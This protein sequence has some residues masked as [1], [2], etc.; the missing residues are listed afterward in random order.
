MRVLIVDDE[1]L[2]RVGVRHACARHADIEVVGEAGDGVAA[3]EQIAALAP[4]ALFLDVQMPGL[5]G[6]E[7]LAALPPAQRPAVVFVTAYDEHAVRAFELNALD[8]LLKPF[9]DA[10]FDAAVQR[11]RERLDG[12]RESAVADRLDAVVRELRGGAWADRVLATIGSR[13]FVI[14]TADISWLEAAD[15]YVRVHAGER[16]GL[17]R[18]TLASL[19]QRLDPARFLRVHRSAI[20]NLERISELRPRT[21][22]DYEVRLSDGSSC[23]A[24]R[25]RSAELLTRLRGPGGR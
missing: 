19:E 23:I 2:V 7:V 10:R 12:E 9:D 21:N 13:V 4:D 3:L 6:V 18:E 17:L 14:P 5:T 16:S 22:G 24:S 8:Y 25:T 15:N 20:V 11:L 1:P